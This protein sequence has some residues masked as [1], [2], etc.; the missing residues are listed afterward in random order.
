M[1]NPNI[2]VL[3]KEN[4]EFFPSDKFKSQA[5]VRDLKIFE[6]AISLVASQPIPQTVS[7]GYKINPPRCKTPR[8]VFIS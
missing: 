3:L 7:V 6:T 8:Q 1:T 4:R 2:D 5:H